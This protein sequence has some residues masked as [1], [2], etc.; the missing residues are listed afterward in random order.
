ME[1]TTL[2]LLDRLLVIFLVIDVFVGLYLILTYDIVGIAIAPNLSGYTALQ[3]FTMWWGRLVIHT[4]YLL[5]HLYVFSFG[6]FS[7]LIRAIIVR[8]VK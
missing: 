1:R 8:N 3:L 7:L 6:L 2:G 5:P 4:D